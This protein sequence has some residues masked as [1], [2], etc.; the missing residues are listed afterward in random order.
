MSPEELEGALRAG[1]ADRCL[2][3][4]AGAAEPERRTAAALAARWY[5]AVID[6]H[7]GQE[8]AEGIEL[9]ERGPALERVC[10]AASVCLMGTAVLSELKKLGW[11]TW[12]LRDRGYEAL[13]A[14]APEWLAEWADWFLEQYGRGFPY[15]RSMVRAG[16]LP[17][18]ECD[19]YIVAMLGHVWPES[20]LDLLRRDPELL[21]HEVWRLFEVEGGGEDSLAARDKYTAAER[22]WSTALVTLAGEGALDRDRLLN[23]SLDALERDF[24]QFRASWFSRFHEALSPT[25]D[26]RAARVERYLALVGSSIPPTVSFAL[27]ALEALD[28]ADRLPAD[29]AVAA[30]PPALFAREKGTVRQALRLMERAA[31]RDP[32]LASRVAMAAAGALVHE[33]PEVQEALLKSVEALGDPAD[34]DLGEALR[35]RLEDVAAANRERLTGLLGAAPPAAPAAPAPALF[36]QLLASAGRVPPDLARLAGVDAAA[37]AVRNGA[38]APALRLEEL[39]FPRLDPDAWI[40][41]VRE[42]D[43]LLDLCAAAIENEGPPDDIERVLDGVSRLCDARPP[44]FERR[45]AP[46]LK[47]ARKLAA[48][49]CFSGM[50]PR[51]DLSGLAVAWLA[52][53]VA[54]PER[55]PARLAVFLS[56]RVLEVARR[57]AAGRSA[58][59]LA[60]P[61]HSGGW[62]DPRE[63]VERLSA[64][65]G[66]PDR[67]DLIQALLRLAP[68]HRHEALTKAAGLTG[69]TGAA[70]RHAL[71]AEGVRVGPTAPLWAAAA[72]ARSP[73]EDDPAVHAA[74]PKLGPNGG[75]AVRPRLTWSRRQTNQYVHW[76][77]ALDLGMPRPN[78]PS[79]ELPALLHL[80]H[81]DWG[82]TESPAVRAWA[83]TVWPAGRESWLAAGALELCRNLDWWEAR[84]GNRAY[85]EPLLHPDTPLGPMARLALGLGLAAKDAGESTLATD[86]F[87]AAVRDGR[88]DSD[89]LAGILMFLI[90]PGP[91]KPPRLAKTL[92][93][94]A[95]ASELHAMVVREGLLRALAAKPEIRPAD[96]GPLLELLREL[97]V[98]TGEAVTEPGARE[99]LQSVAGTGKAASLAKALLKLDGPGEDRRAAAAHALAGRLERAERWAR[100][101]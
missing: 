47:R 19:A 64:T 91:V 93:D 20:A 14:R 3:L 23:A 15:V 100:S 96:L 59:L 6:G 49:G 55:S 35:A 98:R 18:P 90:K 32:A 72:R 80:Y 73:L 16:L 25:L 92:A 95:R 54:R 67:L 99:Y 61:T 50:G 36:E 78:P 12:H 29:A 41:P 46:L 1:D 2:S 83:A 22:S 94:G 56:R 37:E 48:D 88:L 44:D 86:A 85:L 9:P 4:L 51:S 82:E 53:A 74:H 42:L 21:E 33:A 52:G 97:C 65:A 77:E 38:E 75:R 34:P 62:L 45:S 11:R 60:A 79:V 39:A 26:E 10:D 43:E 70:V 13:A 66:E 30:L 17:R 101:R 81:H 28:R 87:I 63:F 71:G 69:E 84:W 7:T 31:R 24:A 58:P 27:K 76:D 89:I 8:S 5:R 40:P 68:D 57:A